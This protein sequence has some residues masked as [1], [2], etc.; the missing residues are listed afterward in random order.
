M[1]KFRPHSSTSDST[2]PIRLR[3]SISLGA[4]VFSLVLPDRPSEIHRWTVAESVMSSMTFICQDKARLRPLLTASSSAVLMWQASS[5]RSQAASSTIEPPTSRATPTAREL[6]STQT[7]ASLPETSHLPLAGSRTFTSAA[8]SRRSVLSSSSSI[9]SSQ[10]AVAS[11]AFLL[12]NAVATRSQ[13][14]TGR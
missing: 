7:L 4:F 11:L 14:Q 12:A 2:M 1:F 5:R 8:V 13:P 6:A 3:M 10:L 9:T